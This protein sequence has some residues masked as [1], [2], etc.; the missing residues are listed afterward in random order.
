MGVEEVWPVPQV[1]TKEYSGQQ[2]QRGLVNDLDQFRLS[3]RVEEEDCTEL[4]QLQEDEDDAGDHPHVQ[5]GDV[6]HPRY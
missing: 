6:G 2:H 1:E 4:H 5:T 3:V